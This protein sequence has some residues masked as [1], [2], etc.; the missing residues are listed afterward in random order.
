MGRVGLKKTTYLS[1]LLPRPFLA[2]GLSLKE[3]RHI[4]YMCITTH[5]GNSSR[6]R[7]IGKFSNH[8]SPPWNV[9]VIGAFPD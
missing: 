5:L 8:T 4:S 6:K 2:Y 9:S 7:N 3:D 1:G